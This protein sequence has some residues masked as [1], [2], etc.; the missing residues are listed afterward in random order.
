[1]LTHRNFIADAA[2]SEAM[3][4]FNATSADVYLSYLPLPHIFERMVQVTHST[5]EEEGKG[6]EGN[7]SR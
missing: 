5:S 2:A 7:E 3:Q 6:R 4:A 1:M